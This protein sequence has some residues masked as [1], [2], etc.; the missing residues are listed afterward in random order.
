MANSVLPT[1]V[2]PRKINEPTGLFGSCNPDRERRTAFA[3]AFTASPWACDGKIY[4]L[5]EDG[6]TFVVQA[7]PEFKL[8]GSH[9]LDQMTLATPAIAR[10]SL[11]IRTFSDLW[12]IQ[13]R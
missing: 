5:S 8:L 7:G 3:T 9:P 10:D 13:G 12:R 2:G 4:C 1:P 6:E 11:F